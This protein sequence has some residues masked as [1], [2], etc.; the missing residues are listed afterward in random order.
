M[1]EFVF[2]FAKCFRVTVGLASNQMFFK[3]FLLLI[4]QVL[5]RWTSRLL[6]TQGLQK[7]YSCIRT[8]IATLISKFMFKFAKPV[9][10]GTLGY[11]I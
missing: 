1:C 11:K 9:L 5:L 4:V 3:N 6:L 2:V 10:V 7:I 8:A